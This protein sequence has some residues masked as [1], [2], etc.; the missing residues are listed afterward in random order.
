[1][2]YNCYIKEEY[3]AQLRIFCLICTN[4]VFGSRHDSL[5]HLDILNIISGL[6]CLVIIC[7]RKFWSVC[8]CRLHGYLC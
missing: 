7:V 2:I 1:M 5:S 3:D 8:I 6:C 4:L